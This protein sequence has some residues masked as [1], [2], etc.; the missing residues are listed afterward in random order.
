MVAVTFIIVILRYFFELGWVW[1]QEI[2]LYLY[3]MSFMLAVGST[4]AQ[5]GYVRV[6]IFY[7]GANKRKKVIV[8]LFGSLFLLIFTCFV[9]FF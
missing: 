4:L 9:I 3:G 1:M 7:R 8:N 5:D 6:D 2:V